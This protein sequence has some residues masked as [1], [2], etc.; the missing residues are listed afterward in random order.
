MA[1]YSFSAAF[2]FF[3]LSIIPATYRLRF[4]NYQSQ[5]WNADQS[6]QNRY[7]CQPNNFSNAGSQTSPYSVDLQLCLMSYIRVCTITNL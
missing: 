5:R 6:A 7:D 2:S 3:H 4:Q 1:G